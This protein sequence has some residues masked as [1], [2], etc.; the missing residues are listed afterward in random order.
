MGK[1]SQDLGVATRLVGAEGLSV[2]TAKN[3]IVSSSVE[4][5]QQEAQSLQEA[6]VERAVLLAQANAHSIG[7][8]LTH[9]E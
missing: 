3:P 7:G 6:V 4:V 8:L 2:D 1:M 9:K 5:S